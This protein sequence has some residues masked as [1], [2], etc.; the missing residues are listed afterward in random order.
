MEYTTRLFKS[1]ANLTQ[2]EALDSLQSSSVFVP[3]SKLV[4]IYNQGGHWIAKVGVP[5]TA[6][7]DIFE[8]EMDE[9]PLD[10]H[11]EEHE[12]HEESESPLEELEE[13]EKE[14]STEKKIEKLEKK[15]DKLLDAL[16]IKDGEESDLLEGLEGPEE[17]PAD[18]PPVPK[19]GPKSEPLPPGSGAKLKPGEVPNKPGMTPVGAPAFASVRTASCEGECE[20]GSCEHCDSKRHANAS[21]PTGPANNAATS[22]GSSASGPV[23]SGPVSESCPACNGKNP[24]CRQCAGNKVQSFVASQMDVDHNVSIRQAKV[25]LENEFKGYRVSRIKR[26]GDY[27]HALVSR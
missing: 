14:D 8:D 7:E 24:Q 25:S 10:I 1:A 2:A 26:D 23:T 3:G 16:G 22:S 12:E 6:A 21:M 17:K 18:L 27:I 9:S 19:G 13:H 4:N 5:K 11:E 15:I 20:E